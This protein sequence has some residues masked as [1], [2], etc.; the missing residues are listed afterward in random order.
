[1]KDNFVYAILK[2]KYIFNEVTKLQALLTNVIKV[3]IT[4]FKKVCCILSWIVYHMYNINLKFQLCTLNSN[5]KSIFIYHYIF[6]VFVH[7]N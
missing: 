7:I 1:M 6:K 5:F 4:N 2:N 3:L